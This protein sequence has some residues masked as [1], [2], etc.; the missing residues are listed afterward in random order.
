MTT[1]A[2]TYAYVRLGILLLGATDRPVTFPPT[3]PPPYV[4]PVCVVKPTSRHSSPYV[5][6]YGSTTVRHCKECGRWVT[7]AAEYGMRLCSSAVAAWDTFHACRPTCPVLP[8]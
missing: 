5:C 1:N 2:G 8:Q 3:P 7:G 4:L 6:M